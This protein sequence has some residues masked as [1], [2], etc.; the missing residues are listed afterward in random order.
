MKGMAM[1]LEALIGLPL[2]SME[3]CEPWAKALAPQGFLAGAFVLT[4]GSDAA[5]TSLV[6]TSPLRHQN[7]QKGTIYGLA[8][9]DAV[10]LGYRL[11]VCGVAD[12]ALLRSTATTA[13]WAP[14]TRLAHATTAQTLIGIDVTAERHE[15]DVPRRGIDLAF[16]SGQRIRLS[17]RAD[18]D[19]CIELATP[20][21]HVEIDRITVDE[22]EQD[23]GWLH[24]AAPESFILNDQVWRSA[25]VTD[26][27]HALRKALQSQQTPDAYYRQILRQALTARFR[28]TPQL[29]QRLLALRYPIHV[30]DVP[31]SLIEEIA[32]TLRHQ[33]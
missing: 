18:L 8:S 32:Q 20:G 26:W 14:W 23:F 9:G 13:Q 22:P 25:K 15:C 10:S 1:Q 31:D 2:T 27:P 12:T 29:K 6:C 21:Q 4:F 19:G 28:Q 16:A 17:Y 5:A 7:C 24:P 11:T 3:V 33:A 30:K